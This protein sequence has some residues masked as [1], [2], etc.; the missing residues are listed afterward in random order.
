MTATRLAGTF[1]FHAFRVISA[2]VFSSIDVTDGT[3]DVPVI[4]MK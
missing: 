4:D 2:G 1:S 3:F